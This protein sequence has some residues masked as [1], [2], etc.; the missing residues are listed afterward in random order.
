MGAG[1]MAAAVMAGVSTALGGTLLFFCAGHGGGEG[2]AVGRLAELGLGLRLALGLGE[3]L[4]FERNAGDMAKDSAAKPWQ[5]AC[6]DDDADNEDEDEDEDDG[7]DDGDGG[8]GAS[9]AE[10]CE[11][12]NW[13]AELGG[14]RRAEEE[15]EGEGEEEAPVEVKLVL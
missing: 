11:S 14:R 8:G 3:K 15:G 7:D 9:V 10:L 12:S 1:A 2:A 5:A 13:R 6:G 4:G